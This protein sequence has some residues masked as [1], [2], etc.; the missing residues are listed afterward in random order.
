[1][2]LVITIQSDDDTDITFIRDQAVAAVHNVLDDNDSR[3]D[4]T[5]TCEAEYAD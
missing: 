5:V 4:G 2:K 1:M 3:F